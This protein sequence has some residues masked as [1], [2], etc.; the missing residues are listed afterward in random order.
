[1]VVEMAKRGEISD[2]KS[3]A[4]IIMAQSYLENLK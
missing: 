4:A 2:A 1:M 3:L